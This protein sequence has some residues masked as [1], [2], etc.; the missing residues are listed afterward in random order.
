MPAPRRATTPLFLE[1]TRLPISGTSIASPL[2]SEGELKR[3]LSDLRVDVSSPAAV[4]EIY[5]SLASIIGKWMSEQQ[6]LEASS[7]AGSLLATA[8][9]LDEASLVL[10]GF[11]TGLHS[12]LEIAVAS[13]I[14]KYLALDPT[15]GS[16]AKAQEL[17]SSFRQDAARIAHVCMVARADLPDGP[18]QSG[19]RAL[20]W[21]DELTALLL[22][23]A[24]RADGARTSWR[25]RHRVRIGWLLE[26]AQALEPFLY[27]E[28]RSPSAEA[29]GKRLQRSRRRLRDA[30][31]QNR[32]AC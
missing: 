31:G 21:Y 24:N 30:K 3:V 12:D 11:E 22:D 7:V 4:H 18:E 17:I 2:R 13:R 1:M 27:R 32:T 6:R 9:S 8:R 15:V 29:C 5:L 20:D 28:M 26:A 14:A 23:L 19:R 10:G 16:L 25:G